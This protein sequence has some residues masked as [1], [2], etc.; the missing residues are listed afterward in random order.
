MKLL[1]EI[2]DEQNPPAVISVGDMVSRNL[3]ELQHHPSIAIIDNQTKRKK[4]APKNISQ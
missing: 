2:V 3:H 1:K 4:A